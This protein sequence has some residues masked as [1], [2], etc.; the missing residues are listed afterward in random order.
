VIGLK[1]FLVGAVMGALF[2]SSM[3][4]VSRQTDLIARKRVKPVA[5]P[6][7]YWTMP[8]DGRSL[9]CNVAFVEVK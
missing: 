4:T 1:Q 9:A 2:V 8:D 5:A 6:R 7:A 3:V